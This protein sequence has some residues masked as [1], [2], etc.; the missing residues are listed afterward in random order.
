MIIH[1]VKSGDTIFNIARKYGVPPQKI[2]ENNELHNPDRL[3]VGEKLLIF[4]PT[5]SYSARANDTLSDISD[6]FGVPIG[7]LKR[8]NPYLNG[9]EAL[10]PGQILT[11]KT[12]EPTYGIGI[13]NGY[14]YRGATEER[15][16]LALPYLSYLTVGGARIKSGTAE[17]VFKADNIVS[18]ARECGVMPLLRV[19]DQERDFDERKRESILSA[20]LSGNYGG[21]TIAAWM[22]MKEAKAACEEHLARLHEMAKE[23]GLKLFLEVDGNN[24]YSHGET[25]DAYVLY[26]DKCHMKS[27]P[28]FDEGERR[29]LEGYSDRQKPEKAFIDISSVAYSG[30]EALSKAEAI[31][32][33]QGAGKEIDFD[34]ALLVSSYEYY[35]YQK[36]IRETIRVA[37]E[38]AE[39]IKAK[40]DLIR[41]LGFMGIAF[42]IMQIPCEYLLMFDELYKIPER[43]PEM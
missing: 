3:T 14:C 27:I 32:L 19:Y 13:A 5:R 16:D 15:L 23:R 39:N 12:P 30:S 25:A 11:V 17:T 31:R 10:Y 36:G 26:Y 18:Q 40:L 9:K 28:S 24:D 35:K 42:D 37:F 20:A 6:R 41:E 4:T 22:G 43:H 21:V 34:K 38:T 33:A 7:E 2:I 8:K 29:T 1:T